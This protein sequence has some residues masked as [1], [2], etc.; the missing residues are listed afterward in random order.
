MTELSAVPPHV[1]THLVRDFDFAAIPGAHDDV[2]LAWQRLHDGPRLFWSPH[3]GGH[4]VATR[5]DDIERIQTDHRVFSHRE[6]SLPRG[7]KPFPFVPLEADPPE[8]ADYRRVIAP[9]FSP[10]V[11]AKLE[12]QVR[13]L[14]ISLIESFKPRGSCEFVA[15][16]A[17]HLPVTVF[18]GM[19]DLPLA[20]RERFIAW[21]EVMT[22]ATSSKEKQDV[23][24]QTVEYLSRFIAERTASPKDDLISRVVKAEVNGRPVRQDEVLGMTTLLFFGGLDTVASMLS[25][26][27]RFLA[28]NPSHRRQ[29]IDDPKLIPGAIE[30]FLRR[31]GLSNTVRILN[32]D[33][34]L[35]GV[36]LKKDDIIMVPISLHGLDERRF[37]D[38]LSLDFKRKPVHATFGNGPH[39]CPGSNLARTEVRVF[40]EEWLKRIP[41]FEITPG[42][43]SRTATGAVNT[44]TYLPLSWPLTDRGTTDKR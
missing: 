44:V 20:E 38:A 5:A 10:V 19:I 13:E 9:F 21:G 40:L 2:H 4:W 18:L 32:E 41:E 39:R 42:E 12:S 11:V 26:V 3:Y 6:F 35:G 23:L 27:A 14:T 7:Y 8:H 34:E 15:E 17:R 31:H 16:F 1:P 36:Q 22:R 28:R 25:F 29:L 33:A 37:P 30:E 43:Q 24:R